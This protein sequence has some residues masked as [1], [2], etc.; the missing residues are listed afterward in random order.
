MADK[1]EKERKTARMVGV[2][3]TIPFVLAV[4]PI[5]GWFIGDWLDK[6]LDTAPFLMYLML[7]LGFVAGVRELYRIV[8]DF[9]DEN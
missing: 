6:Q 9:S 1:E 8:K 7:I 2:Y 4:P 5:L 3:I